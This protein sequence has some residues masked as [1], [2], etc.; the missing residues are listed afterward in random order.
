MQQPIV[1]I[2]MD[3]AMMNLQDR[4]SK[5]PRDLLI[6]SAAQSIF[7]CKKCGICCEQIN[8]VALSSKDETRVRKQLKIRKNIYN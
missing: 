4:L 3:N 7:E 2:P 1:V 5:V 6:M 8:G